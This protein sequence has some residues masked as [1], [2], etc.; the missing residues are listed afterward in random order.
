M[1]VKPNKNYSLCST[2]ISVSKD[3]TYKAIIATNQ[4]NYKE[5]GAIFVN[6]ILL[7][8]GEYIIVEK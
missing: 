4:P 2:N 3:Q 8:R 5:K 1:L 7:E 6:K